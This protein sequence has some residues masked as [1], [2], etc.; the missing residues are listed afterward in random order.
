MMRMVWAAV[1]LLALA[2]GCADGE[3][4]ADGGADTDADTDSDSDADADGGGSLGAVEVTG[5]WD[6]AQPEGVTLKTAVFA[7]PWTMPPTYSDLD[8]TIDP[9]T[10][11][12]HGLVEGIEPGAWCLM[13]YVD[14][15]PADGLAPVDGLDAVNATG[16]ENENG[17]IPVEIAAGETLQLTLTFAVQ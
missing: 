6:G 3:S 4:E 7:C 13:A 12:V 16:A 11:A 15:D 10:G 8:G 14:M 9:G 17:A 5:V 2:S 1:G